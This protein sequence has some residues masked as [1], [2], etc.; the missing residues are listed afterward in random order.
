MLKIKF[1]KKMKRDAKRMEKR[2]K[3]MSKLDI[4]LG[5][6]VLRQPLPQKYGDHSLK[7]TM[8]DFREC[9]IEPDWLLV[10]CVWAD[11]LILLATATGTHSDV[12]GT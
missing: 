9:H 11:E 2:G 12:F 1:T 3:D 8:R 10:Y 6:L 7:G 5:L 4:V